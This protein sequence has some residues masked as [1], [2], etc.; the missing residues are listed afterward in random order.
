MSTTGMFQP[1]TSL[2]LVN[3]I[4]Q[5]HFKTIIVACLLLRFIIKLHS[6]LN[7]TIWNLYFFSVFLPD[8]TRESTTV[9]TSITSK[10]FT[11]RWPHKQ[12]DW[13]SANFS[14][15]SNLTTII[16]TTKLCITRTPS[17]KLAPLSSSPQ[18]ASAS[19]WYFFKT[20]GIKALWVSVEFSSIQMM[21]FIR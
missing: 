21:A 1:L 8:F 5:Q 11:N 9:G 12:I 20:R 3:F 4:M 10:E 14:N 18:T 16:T 2:G 17:S 15:T 19:P 7:C 6:P 13:K